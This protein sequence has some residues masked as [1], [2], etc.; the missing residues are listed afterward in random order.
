MTSKLETAVGEAARLDKFLAASF[1]DI[2]RAR[3][4]KLIADGAVRVDGAV[5]DDAGLKLRPGQTIAVTVP[6]A[7]PA[8][9]E[10]EDIALDVVFEDKH[11]IVIN[12]PAGL[13]VHPA[14][15]A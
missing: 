12:K 15:G 11:V 6:P 1:P 7:A 3:F 8:E 5:A 4:Q 9:P 14:A 2:S 10:A 13:V